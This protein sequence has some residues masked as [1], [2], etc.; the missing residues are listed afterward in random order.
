[1][2]GDTPTVAPI[3]FA[4]LGLSEPSPLVGA[5]LGAIRAAPTMNRIGVDGSREAAAN[6]ATVP[7][8][9]EMWRVAQH[10]I[11]P[12]D[13]EFDVRVY[14]ASN[15]PGQPI[16]VYFHAGGW[17]L[18]DL[19]HSDHLCRRMADQT[20]A[21]VVNVDYR[22]A[23]EAPFP[24]AFDDCV[25]AV[26]WARTHADDIGGDRTRIALAGE[27]SG[28]G[29]AAAV[30][31][32]AG[33]DAGLQFL[34][35]LEPALDINMSTP[36]WQSLGGLLPPAREQMEWMWH[37]YA[38]DEA[39][40]TDPR[41]TPAS[42]DSVPTAHPATLIL[43][44]EYDPLRDEAMRYAEMLA[45]SGVT[46]DARLEQGLPH[47]FCNMGGILPEGLQAF[48]RAVAEMNRHLRAGP[49]SRS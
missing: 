11:G 31:A 40:H 6:R 49:A 21:V 13:A 27:S 41:L 28:G 45:R 4:G 17:I 20:G 48:D 5:I 18:G 29:L 1:M 10:R 3:D 2:S 16:V 7:E 36:S 9:E 24:A 42:A 14:R 25:A 46:V 22:L 26:R 44:A 23:P 35:L 39:T 15:E 38:P 30:A 34:L 12:D 32:S 19:E 47:A 8:R 37:Q 33:D 43:A